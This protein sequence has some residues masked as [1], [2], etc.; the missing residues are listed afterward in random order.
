[1]IRRLFVLFTI[2]STLCLSAQKG[3]MD[4]QY[5]ARKIEVNEPLTVVYNLHNMEE[6]GML[7]SKWDPFVLVGG[8]SI[9]RSMNT[10]IVNGQMSQSQTNS[11]TV[12]LVSKKTGKLMVP[13]AYFQLSDG[14]RVETQS[15]EVEVVKEGTIPRQQTRQSNPFDPFSAFFDPF[16]PFANS[17]MGMPQR[18]APQQSSPSNSG[19][20][21]D[22]SKID[23]KKDIF[24]QIFVNKR[25]AYVGEQLTASVKIYTAVNSKG[26]EAEK[27]PNF[28]GFWS[29][30]IRLPEPLEMKR[31]TL[32]GKEYVSVEIK[33]ILL[34]PTKP[35]LLEIS[36]L[37]MRTVALV[38]VKVNRQQNQRQPRDLF[39]AIQMM[40]SQDMNVFGG[41]EY[42]EVPYSFSS[43]NTTIEV[44]PLPANAPKSFTGA[45]GKYSM[46]AFSN[47][48][49]LKTDEALTYSIEIKG[50]GNLPL[51]ENPKMEWDADLEVYDPQL[52]ENYNTSPNFNGSKT[53]N[54]T[55]IPHNP[56]TYS[57]PPFEFS[58]FNIESKRYETISSPATALTITGSP[59]ARKSKG[60]T[61]AEYD[62]AKQKIK[63]STNYSP[64]S[65]ISNIS[66]FGWSLLPLILALGIAIVPKSTIKNERFASGKK[67]SEQVRRQ[68]QLASTYLKN[69]DKKLFYNEITRA[70]WAYL[71]NRLRIEPSLLSKDNIADK[72]RQRNVPE[73][74]I[75]EVISLIE[76]A[77]MGLYTSYGAKGMQEQYH[78]SLEVLS[79]LEKQLV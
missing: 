61:Y 33:K 68:M 13:K 66:Y 46:N 52:K 72:L 51:I 39:D 74:T 55:V 9:G 15:F 40:M 76:N 71:G 5:S 41:V 48:K 4:I 31:E 2:I 57:T 23:L 32:G 47:K 79:E 35:G 8:P 17:G 42:K 69:N 7:Q 38:P 12:Q 37:K 60:K 58:Y 36:P 24:A 54:Y 34:F 3:T 49:E 22:P 27:L 70:Y 28:N 44:L 10:S 45:V 6:R 73:E 1:M 43:G 64:Q 77:E 78:Q 50:S 25:K 63:E 53:W 29:Q 67:V 19:V 56:G 65:K 26:F 11:Y 62:Y 18:H 59:T 16:D 20:Y 14:S 75:S 30:D 21:T